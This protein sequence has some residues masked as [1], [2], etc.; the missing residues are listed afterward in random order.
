MGREGRLTRAGHARQ[1]EFVSFRSSQGDVVQELVPQ[2]VVI[3]D[4]FRA[5]SASQGA[6]FCQI[7]N[8][9]HG[10]AFCVDMG[11]PLVPS[12]SLGGSRWGLKNATTR[13]GF[14]PPSSRWTALGLASFA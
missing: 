12:Y 5:V 4:R 11:V 8:V 2:N 9:D 6:E 13:P 14:L 10:L 7:L 3:K 1:D